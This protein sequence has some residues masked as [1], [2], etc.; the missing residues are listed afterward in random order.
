MHKLHFHLNGNQIPKPLM[1]LF[2]CFAGYRSESNYLL[3]YAGTWYRKARDLR[4]HRYLNSQLIKHLF[5]TDMILKDTSSWN[6][7]VRGI[8]SVNCGVLCGWHGWNAIYFWLIFV[9][10]NDIKNAF[11]LWSRNTHNWKEILLLLTQNT[12]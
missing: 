8:I 9:I 10:N 11:I 1:L 3:C 12:V 6:R 4:H 5:L 7:H 2:S